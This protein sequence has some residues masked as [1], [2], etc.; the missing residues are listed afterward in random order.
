MSWGAPATAPATPRHALPV[1][2]VVG[3][4]VAALAACSM[5]GALPLEAQEP[6]GPAG[7]CQLEFSARDAANPPRVTS[8]KQPSGQFNSWIGGGVIARCPAQSS[9]LTADSAEYFG[10]RRLLHL[11][12]NVHYTEPRLTL[13][14]RLAN[15]FMA[16]ERLEAEGNVHTVLPSGT[17]WMAEDGVLRA[18]PVCRD[19]RM[20]RGPPTSNVQATHRKLRA[21]TGSPHVTCSDARLR[22]QVI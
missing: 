19:D 8:V 17:R 15:Y 12:G 3:V 16:E 6:T 1:T 7:R 22:R 11:I 9:T 13:D 18:V 2:L 10:D 14:S 21:M 5:L 20:E 4:T